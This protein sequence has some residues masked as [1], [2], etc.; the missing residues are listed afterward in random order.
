M[1]VIGE[2]RGVR[3]P[4]TGVTST[5]EPSDVSVGWESNSAIIL[6]NM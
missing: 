2:D 1:W 3:P 5:Y 6:L 4:R